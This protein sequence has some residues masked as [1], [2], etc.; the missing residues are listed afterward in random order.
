M[1]LVG[2]AMM[3]PVMAQWTPGDSSMSV[4]D[5]GKD[6]DYYNPTMIR[7]ADGGSILAY[8]TFGLHINPE[9]GVQ[10]AD[11]YFYLHMQVLDKAG[12][13][14]FPAE[15][16]I[17]SSQPTRMAVLGLIGLDTL[18]NG[19]VVLTNA[20]IREQ[21]TDPADFPYVYAYC[22]TQQGMPVWSK[23]GVQLPV[24]KQHPEASTR[25]CLAERIAVSGDYI[26]FAAMIQET[27]LQDTGQQQG[28]QYFHYF[29]LACLDYN[30]N[31]LASN[32]E[33]V[34]DAFQYAISPAPE[35][36]LYM[37]YVNDNE[38]YSARCITPDCQ[39]S[40]A[41]DVVVDTLSVVRYSGS[42]H[43]GHAPSEMIPQ[44]DGSLLMLYDAYLNSGSSVLIYNRLNPDGSLFG[45]RA[46]LTD[47]IGLHEGHTCLL[48]GNELVVIENRERPIADGRTEYYLW[49]NRVR[50]SDGVSLLNDP[51]GYMLDMTYD[52]HPEMIGLVKADNRLQWLA[53]YQ[54]EY[55]GTAQ[56]YA[57]TIGLDGTKIM[58]KPILGD[59]SLN[60]HAFASEAPYAYLFFSKGENGTDGLWIACID[61]TDYTHAAPQTGE[62]PT[63]A[64]TV[65]AE[66]KQ[67]VFSQGN[68]QYLPY[69]HT[70]HLATKQWESLTYING[71]LSEDNINWMDLYGWGT[72]DKGDKTSTSDADYATFTEWGTNAVLN[73]TY[74]A[75]TWRTMTADEWT[76]LF[77]GRPDAASK[78]TLG[79][80]T[81]P[82]R[83]PSIDG[84][85]LLPDTFVMPDTLQMDMNAQTYDVNA[86]I[87]TE[88][89]QLE[90]KGAVFL[91]MDG[92]RE[93]TE[94]YALPDGQSTATK[95]LYWTSS[96]DG[97]TKAH[98]LLIDSVGTSFAAKNRAIG[99]SV[100]LV[101][102]VNSGQG[103]EET[104]AKTRAMKVLRDGQLFIIRDDQIFTVTGTKVL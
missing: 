29:E 81:F 26:Y 38:G 99:M 31:V 71:W 11:R 96:A 57:Y 37:V 48:D 30:G 9:T 36:K 80:I 88:W 50:L 35:G 2:A 66:G 6:Y 84:V 86:Y 16:V 43:V 97:A 94:V 92:Y 77:N 67:V 72:G 58:R 20:D 54:D 13:A 69:R 23:D 10:D 53:Y 21:T 61:V 32:I 39:N 44:S 40:W 5:Q 73:S 24:L 102:D 100:R 47:T 19:N 103:I 104:R 45:H 33:P 46:I 27:V 74:E 15:G 83:E 85:I 18:S 68:L 28:V 7:K 22:Y 76:Y 95:G 90:A 101:K 17:V 41:E 12:K 78:R 62:M 93:G 14:Q 79:S 89:M 70:Y 75:G 87:P 65:N 1:A 91:P 60:E 59:A 52:A 25:S 3:L 98:C 82:D 49:Y 34:N 64:F 8:R 4:I 55:Y 51:Y 56:C 42:A 63:G